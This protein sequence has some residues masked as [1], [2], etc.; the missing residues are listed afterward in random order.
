M[1]QGLLDGQWR[2]RRGN[3]SLLQLSVEGARHR[4]PDA[5]GHQKIALGPEDGA[6]MPFNKDSAVSAEDNHAVDLLD[7][8][9]EPVIDNEDAAIRVML[10]QQRVQA[11]GCLGCKMRRRL[12]GHEQGSILHKG[13]GQGD[14]LPLAP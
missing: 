4:T 5:L 8:A 13:R 14:E 7:Q 2:H 3:A 6:R 11:V 9:L 12:V 10:R 1:C